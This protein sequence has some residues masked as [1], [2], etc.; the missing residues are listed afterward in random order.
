VTLSLVNRYN[1]TWPLA[2]E[3]V[4]SAGST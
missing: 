3:L 2:I 1:H 4:S